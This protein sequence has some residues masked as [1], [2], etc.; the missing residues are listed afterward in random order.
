MTDFVH[1]GAWLMLGDSLVRLRSLADNS[2]DSI[3]CDP[4]YHLDT[5]V[6]RF[7]KVTSAPAQHGND[8]AFARSSDKFLGDTWDDGDIAFKPEIWRECLRVLKPGGHLLAFSHSRLYHRMATAIEDAGFEI[9][10]SIMWLYGTGLPKSHKQPGGWGT[11]LKPA[12][13]PIAMARKPFK[14]SVR[15]N[16]AVWGT[17]GINIE[18]CRNGKRFPA[19]VV[20]DFDEPW[21][22]YFYC[23]KA[24]AE[25]R[26]LF[27]DHPTVKPQELMSW[28]CQLVTPSGGTVLDP[29]TGS[30]ST[31]VAALRNGYGFIGV[32]QDVNY[33]STAM[34]RINT[35]D[36]TGK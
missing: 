3:V 18:A 33:F 29:F 22:M 17:G 31:G 1:L 13:E 27:N 20:T 16:M 12:H 26:G 30:G 11:A 23:A 21:S 28:L 32:E 19:N 10:D 36:D 35:I 2:I 9:R 14:G 4:P 25:D 34:L 24:S 5:I 15:A 7:G 8:G 6:K